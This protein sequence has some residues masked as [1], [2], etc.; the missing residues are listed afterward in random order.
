MIVYK[1]YQG[2]K[3][4]CFSQ[5]SYLFGLLVVNLTERHQS[6]PC[7]IHIDIEINN[8]SHRVSRF[9]MGFIFLALRILT[10]RTD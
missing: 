6:F 2:L 4:L 7:V 5:I 3:F 1:R 10:S 8:C 9:K